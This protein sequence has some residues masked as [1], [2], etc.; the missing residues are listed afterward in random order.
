MSVQIDLNDVEIAKV[1][2]LKNK[3][4]SYKKIIEM[5]G[6]SEW[7]I[8]KYCNNNGLSTEEQ[9]Q[10]G[11]KCSSIYYPTIDH[12]IPLSKGGLHSWNNIQLA[13]L[14]CNSSKGAS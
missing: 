6:C 5:T 3:G 9:N 13:H 1:V 4:L 14:S 11:K 7:T 8:R 10:N 12:I 2:E